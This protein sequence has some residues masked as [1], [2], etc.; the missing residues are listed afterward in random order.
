MPR[1]VVGERCGSWM[2]RASGVCK[3]EL[4]FVRSGNAFS[5]SCHHD[6]RECTAGYSDS[7]MDF[8]SHVVAPVL[9]NRIP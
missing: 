1:E 8:D 3:L 5:T 9:L 7:G 6:Y 2:G 4:G